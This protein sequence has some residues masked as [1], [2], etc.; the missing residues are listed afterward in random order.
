MTAG[1][2][3]PGMHL[4]VPDIEPEVWEMDDAERLMRD[5][6]VLSHAVA[7]Y[8]NADDGDYPEAHHH[9]FAVIADRIEAAH[10]DGFAAGISAAEEGHR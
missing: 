4:P 2:W 9:L 10:D 7:A 5:D 3:E 1:P 8:W 6:P